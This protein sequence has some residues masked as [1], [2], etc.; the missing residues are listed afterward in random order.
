MLDRAELV[1]YRLSCK[2]KSWPKTAV[3]LGQISILAKLRA[4][5]LDLIWG[6]HSPKSWCL[7]LGAI[8]PRLGCYAITQ[9]MPDLGR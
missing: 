5:S 4:Q 6:S 3:R 2:A 9:C 7:N 8:Q 1:I